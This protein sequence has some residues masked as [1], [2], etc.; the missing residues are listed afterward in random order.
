MEFFSRIFVGLL[1]GFTAVV[2]YRKFAFR[3]SNPSAFKFDMIIMLTIAGFMFFVTDPESGRPPKAVSTPVAAPPV[4][5]SEAPIA[6]VLPLP[7]ETRWS[8]PAGHYVL[9]LIATESRVEFTAINPSAQLQTAGIRNGSTLFEGSRA[10][11]KL[12]GTVYDFQ[13]KCGVTKRRFT[14]NIPADQRTID[15]TAQLASG[16]DDQCRPTVQ[17]MKVAF[18]RVD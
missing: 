11:N 10:G 3:G 5:R 17:D 12:E 8:P 7:P 6:S 18:K 2:L 13:G 9:R 16:H 15:L 1:L 14:A 4:T